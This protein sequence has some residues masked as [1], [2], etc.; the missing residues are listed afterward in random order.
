MSD[1]P[2][3]VAIVGANLAGGTAAWRLRE[4]GYDDRIAL[5]GEEAL[6]PYERPSLSKEYL[7]GQEDEI[8]SLR[9]AEW[10]DEAS[11]ETH[12]GVRAE[13]LDT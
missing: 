11:I 8:H 5:I 7:R 1:A 6:P 2:R 9:P 12:F 10:W 4:E 13:S 3:V